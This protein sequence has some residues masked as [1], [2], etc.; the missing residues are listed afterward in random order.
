MP[1]NVITEKGPSG[2]CNWR[3]FKR[4]PVSQGSIL[5]VFTYICIFTKMRN[6]KEAKESILWP[7]PKHMGMLRAGMLNLIVYPESHIRSSVLLLHHH[8]RAVNFQSS[9]KVQIVVSLRVIFPS[10]RSLTFSRRS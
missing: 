8:H 9:L 2:D 1:L 4:D 5:Y 3:P 10:I 6:R 7:L